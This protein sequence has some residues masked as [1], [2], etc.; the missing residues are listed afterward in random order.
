MMENV[1][2]K[3]CAEKEIQALVTR[4][5]SVLTGGTVWLQ[6]N[7]RI[8][9]DLPH[10]VLFWSF[11]TE[12]QMWSL[13]KWCPTFILLVLTSPTTVVV[14]PN[15][16]VLNGICNHSRNWYCF[17]IQL[18]LRGIDFILCCV[19]KLNISLPHLNCCY[20][21]GS[22]LHMEALKLR[23]DPACTE[24]WDLNQ[25]LRFQRNFKRSATGGQFA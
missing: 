7:E 16:S 21:V 22:V 20:T 23:V 13:F 5:P 9:E 19:S 6:V 17:F 14:A 15:C 18:F 3:G 8:P 1:F 25:G 11:L 24:E 12:R 2:C 10:F 4:A